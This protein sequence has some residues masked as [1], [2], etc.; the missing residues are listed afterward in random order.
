MCFEQ[1]REKNCLKQDDERTNGQKF[2]VRWRLAQSRRLFVAGKVTYEHS[3]DSISKFER[4]SRLEML[5]RDYRRRFGETELI[6]WED[7]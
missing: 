3:P 4:P 1:E 7:Q 6:V 2:Y 5:E